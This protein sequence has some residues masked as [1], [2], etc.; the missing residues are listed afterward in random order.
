[1]KRTKLQGF[2]LIELLVVIAIIAILAAILFP[3]FAQAKL[4]A[5]KIADISNMKQI[6]LG[7]QM[8]ASD[9]DDQ[10]PQAAT[11]DASISTFVLW[12]STPTLQPYLK[13]REILKSPAEGGAN[14]NVPVASLPAGV[15]SAPQRSYFVN[16]FYDADIQANAAAVFGPDF[17][18]SA[19][20]VF[21]VRDGAGTILG[22]G[23]GMGAFS[24]PS[25]L[26]LLFG[27]A[28]AAQ[29]TMG[30]TGLANTEVLYN[31]SLELITGLD[32][33]DF[34][35]GTW[36]GTANNDSRKVWHRF[37]EGSNYGFADSSARFIRAAGLK[38]GQYLDA[39]RFVPDA[40]F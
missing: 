34:A 8:Y 20:G 21:G 31:N 35:N 19:S 32:A 39:R 29:R 24:S 36:G 7:L 33:L 3:V 5:K 6:G 2:T 38:Q 27:G 11:Y 15:N 17:V 40:G 12:S 37:T 14:P 16:S 25:D 23:A 28:E 22:S 13:S 1:M 4:A 9:N 10:L 30:Q 26:V 18:G